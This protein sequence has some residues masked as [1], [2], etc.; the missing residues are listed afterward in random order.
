MSQTSPPPPPAAAASAGGDYPV[1]LDLTS[2]N[3]VPRWQPFVGFIL[4]LPHIVVLYGL[5]LWA[6]IATFVSFFTILFTKDVP[7]WAFRANVRVR[8]YSWRVMSYAVFLRPG[9]P[10]FEF[11][12]DPIDQSSDPAKFSMVKPVEYKRF[13][14][15][16][17]WL[18]VFPHL[19]VLGVLVACTYSIVGLIA[20]FSV[21][22]T[23]HW[24][25]GLRNFVIGIFRWSTRVNAYAGLMVDD[26]PPFSLH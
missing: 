7:D 15:L 2:P 24:P 10:P 26:Y 19:I 6:E 9:Y 21:L 11:D 8:R 1:T 22:F 13:L 16:I 5:A 12:A 23:G 14:P 4:V 20:F 3:Q 25:E 17:K 18:L